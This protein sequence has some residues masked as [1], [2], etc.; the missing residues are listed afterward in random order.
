MIFITIEIVSNEEYIMPHTHENFNDIGNVEQSLSSLN[1]ITEKTK[2]EKINI[3]YNHLFMSVISSYICS[4]LIFFILPTTLFKTIWYNAIIAISV[5]R[6]LLIFIRKYNKN[7]NLHLI[8]FILGSTLSAS[9]WGVVGYFLM[10]QDNILQ[11]MVIMIIIAGVSA[12]A[13]QTLQANLISAVL[14]LVLSLLPLSIWLF[15]QNTFEYYVLAIALATYLC[16]CNLSAF[17]GNRLIDQVL[18]LNF[19]NFDLAFRLYT[20]NDELTNKNSLLERHEENMNIINHLNEKLQL[21][22]NST[23]AHSVI[24]I[25]AERLFTDFFGGLTITDTID[26][27]ILVAQWGDK[28]TLNIKFSSDACWAL[29]GGNKYLV[30]DQQKDLLCKHYTILPEGSYCIPLI[31]ENKSLGMINFNFSN[32]IVITNQIIQIMTVFSD[33]VKLA[34]ANIKLREKLQSEATRDP[35]TNLFN[36][37]YLNETLSREFYR[38]ARENN[39][40]CFAILDL[41][42]FKN[43]NDTYGHETGDEVLKYFATLLI[44]HVRGS[45][46]ACRF[47][48]E[49]F[50]LV[51]INTTIDKIMPS[52]ENIRKE[53]ENAKIYVHNQLIHS[54]TTSIG[55]A[56]AP[57]QG[58]TVQDI[59]KAADI[60]LYQAKNAG[61]NTIMTSQLPPSD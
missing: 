57:E 61:R 56:Q 15:I 53:I 49:E 31:V 45:D 34:L 7:P 21:C 13:M 52:L 35:L 20:S 54:V 29:R 4:S 40:L 2:N 48:G 6:F 41:D 33:V 12:G 11:Q 38:I 22:K 59:I 47:G 16:F 24:K 44:N 9:C 8:L 3:L 55:V 32:D 46:I 25:A 5:F 10:P 17:R 60:A 43:L 37:R 14:F 50:A 42:H 27:Q 58:N 36:R 19:K 23:E 28:Q 30:N 1:Y 18:T 39:S 26:N 51:F